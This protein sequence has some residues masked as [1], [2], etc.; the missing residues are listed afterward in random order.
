MK[1]KKKNMFQADS[2]EVSNM[3]L[4]QSSPVAQR[5][6]IINAWWKSWKLFSSSIIVPSVMFWKRN[7]E[8]MD[9]IKKTNKSNPLTLSRAGK[10][11]TVV[12]ISF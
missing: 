5:K 6:S 1:A 4:Y 3:I 9:P 7:T 10:E 11:K 12:S 8:R 2:R